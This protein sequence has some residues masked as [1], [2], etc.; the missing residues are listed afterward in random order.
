MSGEFDSEPVKGLPERLP[1]GETMLWQGQ[2]EW[3]SLAIRVFHIRKIA[4]YFALLL[5]AQAAISLYNGAAGAEAARSAMILAAVGAA[6]CAT[7]AFLG[8]LYAN[9]TVY[10]ITDRRIVMRYGAALPMALNVPFAEI[11]AAAAAIHRDGTADIPLVLESKSRISWL[12]LWPHVRPWRINKPEPM[13]RGVPD[14]RRVAQLLAEAL[15]EAHESAGQPAVID[16]SVGGRAAARPP[17]Q[18]AAA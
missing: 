4:V 8:W 13:L 17:L 11:S 1:A 14:G 10:T 9:T 16:R 7:A 18:P 12:H 3:R 5:A 2:P 15:T 6:A